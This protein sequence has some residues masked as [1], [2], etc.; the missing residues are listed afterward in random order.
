M[1][2]YASS[3]AS[4]LTLVPCPMPQELP[5]PSMEEIESCALLINS[6]FWACWRIDPPLTSRGE[7]GDFFEYTHDYPIAPSQYPMHPVWRFRIPATAGLQQNNMSRVAPQHRAGTICCY[8]E[9]V[10]RFG[11]LRDLCRRGMFERSNVLLF[12]DPMDG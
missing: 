4:Q 2:V 1:S 9:A 5:L 8:L 11:V 7:F 3:L 6:E 10:T 12:R